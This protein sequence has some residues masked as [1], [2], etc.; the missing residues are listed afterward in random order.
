MESKKYILGV[1]L[2]ACAALVV[3]FTMPFYEQS[4][5]EDS[6]DY[7]DSKEFYDDYAYGNLTYPFTCYAI[8]NGSYLKAQCGQFE[9]SEEKL[10][11]ALD[12]S[13]D[14]SPRNREEIEEREKDFEKAKSAWIKSIVFALMANVVFL[15]FIALLAISAYLYGIYDRVNSKHLLFEI[16]R[17]V[18]V[19]PLVVFVGFF[20]FEDSLN[21]SHHTV[22]GIVQVYDLYKFTFNFIPLLAVSAVM[23]VCG[24][25]A[26]PKQVE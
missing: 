22:N 20:I 2:A 7:K 11:E 18:A 13:I 4:Y 8:V 12:E 24:F 15:L 25:M 6:E 17:Y 10:E 14:Y 5:N 16:L 19:V 26:K 3:S 23:A 9:K 21:Y 1:F